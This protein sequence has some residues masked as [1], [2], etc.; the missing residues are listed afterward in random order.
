MLS[1][2]LAHFFLCAASAFQLLLTSSEENS[3][4]VLGLLIV[5]A[6]IIIILTLFKL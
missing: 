6:H 5:F 1:G 2:M 3:L 4:C